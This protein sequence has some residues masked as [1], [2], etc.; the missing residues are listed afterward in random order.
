MQE[1][2][3]M[4]NRISDPSGDS[5]R[6]HRERRNRPD[7]RKIVRWEPE[8]DDRRSRRDRR[9]TGYGIELWDYERRR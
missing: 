4:A 3:A 7:R 6:R 5:E 1:E 8:N 2:P 9:D